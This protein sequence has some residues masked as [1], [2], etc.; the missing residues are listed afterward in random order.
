MT[1]LLCCGTYKHTVRYIPTILLFG[2]ILFGTTK[3]S[4]PPKEREK[5]ERKRRERERD[6]GEREKGQR[7]DAEVSSTL[8]TLT[9]FVQC[10]E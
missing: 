4:S 9:L 3:V 1:L 6:K 7:E 8:H 5:G 2:Y 10:R